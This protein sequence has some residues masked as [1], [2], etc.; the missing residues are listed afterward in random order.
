MTNFSAYD[1]KQ[2][3]KLP[4]AIAALAE[5]YP[6]D[7]LNAA[8]VWDEPPFPEN[9]IPEIIEIYYGETEVSDVLIINGEI[10]DF[11]VRDVDD[12]TPISVLIDDQHTYLQIEGKEIMNRL[13]GVILPELFIDPTTL[14]KSVLGEK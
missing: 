2:I 3:A 1:L 7:I 10:K 6:S 13:G 5:K 14:I 11:R 12:N 9:H 8:E 4:P